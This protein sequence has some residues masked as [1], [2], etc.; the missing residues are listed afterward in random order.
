MRYKHNH[1]SKEHPCLHR[2]QKP[3]DNCLQAMEF[4]KKVETRMGGG[5]PWNKVQGLTH[6]AMPSLNLQGMRVN[7]SM[8]LHL[9][10]LTC[11]NLILVL[12]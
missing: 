10:H 6:S 3:E 2:E 1:G 8:K 9:G 12:R 4:Q 11:L 5:G 7:D